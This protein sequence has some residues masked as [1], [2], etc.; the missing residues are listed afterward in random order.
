MNRRNFLR[1][2]GAAAAVAL[3][4]PERLAWKP[5]ATTHFLPPAEGGWRPRPPF[6][7][8]NPSTNL[9]KQFRDGLM[10]NKDAFALLMDDVNLSVELTPERFPMIDFYPKLPE[11][12]I[13]QLAKDLADRIDAEGLKRYEAEFPH[14]D[15]AFLQGEQWIARDAETG[16][17]MRLVTA[18][19]PRIDVLYGFGVIRDGAVMVKG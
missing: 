2:F 17:S 3:V 5:G 8:F 9:A 11:E 15:I 6:G 16:I 1:L 18:F 4:D 10:F 19:T 14:R 13:A 12:T 7:L